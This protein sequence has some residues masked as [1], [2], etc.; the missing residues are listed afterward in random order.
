MPIDQINQPHGEKPRLFYGYI[1]VGAAF[2]IMALFAGT[3]F[4]F[5]VFF[6]PVLIEFNWTRAM[7]S[8]AFSL[9]WVVQAFLGIVMGRLTDKIG[10]RI[11]L[12]FCGF[13]AG[14]GYILMSQIGA[15][16][17]LYLFYGV[18]IGAGNSIFVPVVSTI[19]RWFTERR[20]MMTGIVA[21]GAGVGSL[22]A[23]PITNWLIINYDWRLSYVILGSVV[24]V[25]IITVAQFLKRDPTS[26]GQVPYGYDK[27]RE[28]RAKTDNEGAYL[29]QAVYTGPFWLILIMFFCSGFCAYAIA[30]H[31]VPYATD[32]GISAASAANILAV[33]GGLAIIGRIVMGSMGDR[34]GNDKA[35]IVGFFL[36]SIALLWLLSAKNA[37]PLYMFAVLFGFA[38]SVGALASPLIAD[39]FGLRSHG[40]IMGLTNIGYCIGGATGP[41]VSGHIFDIT[42]SYRGAFLIN[43]AVAISG[44]ILT[45]LLTLTIGK[46]KK[47][48][49]ELYA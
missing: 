27:R 25:I 41:L 19:A 11:V 39:I 3:R 18:I 26:I 4:A 46:A 42:D 14:V 36:I 34:I 13:L 44:L 15:M 38:W 33:I 9:S 31:I 45:V 28:Q 10:A 12:T 20:S 43:A 40:A 30:V 23:P 2:F 29:K 22:I 1:V 37:L 5:G 16:W 24:L 17:Q 35:Y 49:G 8:G 6:K 21:S 47:R 7:T 48:Q 32:L